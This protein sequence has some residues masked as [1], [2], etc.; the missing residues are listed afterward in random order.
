[1]P[2]ASRLAWAGHHRI[3]SQALERILRRARAGNGTA[4]VGERVLANVCELRRAAATGEGLEHRTTSCFSHLVAVC[5]ALSEI[6]AESLAAGTT[7]ALLRAR[8]AQGLEMLLLKLEH[9]LNAAGPT[10]DS[11]I[12]QYAQRLHGCER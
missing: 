2:S 10:L 11:L 9:D 1:M 7:A 6:G 8:S 12:A 4:S 5:F 3:T